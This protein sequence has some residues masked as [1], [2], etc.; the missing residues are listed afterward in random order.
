M[1]EILENVKVYTLRRRQQGYGNIWTFSSKP[2]EL[3]LNIPLKLL[4]STLSANKRSQMEM[5]STF[6][7]TGKTALGKRRIIIYKCLQKDS[8]TITS[9]FVY[10][11]CKVICKIFGFVKDK[12]NFGFASLSTFG[13]PPSTLCLRTCAK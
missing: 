3:T 11:T 2:V 13:T 5:P 9:L 7:S 12:L 6:S 10:Y 8:L 4:C 1:T